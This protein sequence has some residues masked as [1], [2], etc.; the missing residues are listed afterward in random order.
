[1][2]DTLQSS[3]LVIE[4]IVASPQSQMT[5]VNFQIAR[6]FNTYT[7]AIFWLQSEEAKGKQYIINEVF[8]KAG[9]L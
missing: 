8:A 4:L 3:F 7:Q 5:N 6:K 9:R 2:D 1:M